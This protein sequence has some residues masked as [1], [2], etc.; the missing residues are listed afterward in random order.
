M[1]NFP[2]DPMLKWQWLGALGMPKIRSGGFVIVLILPFSIIVTR[3]F[4][5]SV[6]LHCLGVFDDILVNKYYSPP[7]NSVI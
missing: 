7:I 2:S 6:K 1:F 3:F 4:L 5:L